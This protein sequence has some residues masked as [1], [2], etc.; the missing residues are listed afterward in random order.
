MRAVLDQVF[1][2]MRAGD[3]ETLK[4]LILS[5]TALDRIS[6]NEPVERGTSEGWIGWVSTLKPGQ[7]DEQIFDV[8]SMLKAR[9]QRHGLRLQLRLMVN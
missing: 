8:K 3:A 1:D 5:D 9:L 2:A 4:T 7:A 6:P